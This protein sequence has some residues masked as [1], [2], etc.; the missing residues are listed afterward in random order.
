VNETEFCELGA[1]L[2]PWDKKGNSKPILAGLYDERRIR[3]YGDF[4]PQ[5]LEKYEG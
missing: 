4:L 3:V 1:D 2:Q 5:S